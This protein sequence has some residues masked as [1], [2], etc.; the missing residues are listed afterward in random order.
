MDGE[1][2]EDGSNGDVA[3][4]PY[5]KSKRSRV[6]N[7]AAPSSSA[8]SSTHSSP[9]QPAVRETFLRQIRRRFPNFTPRNDFDILALSGELFAG[10]KAEVYSWLDG[11]LAR[12]AN[13]VGDVEPIL[14]SAK[15][16][17][18]VQDIVT[19]CKPS[20]DTSN[21]IVRPIPH[22]QY[23]LRLFP[24]SVSL[25]QIC[26][27]FVDTSTGMPVNSPFKFEL[28]MASAGCPSVRV[29]SLECSWNVA[30]KDIHPGE[31]KFVLLEGVSYILRRPGHRDLRFTVPMRAPAPSVE[32][33]DELD[34]PRYM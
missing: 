1:G 29:R 25:K 15:K 8:S 19:G 27:D 33:V 13:E 30:Q 6:T 14:A 23:S 5:D 3:N 16:M 9:T 24:G 31:E 11:E 2:E 10:P 20:A 4:Q 21:V 34:L 17:M 22:S 12:I 7:Q 18:D 32:P 28:W 26:M